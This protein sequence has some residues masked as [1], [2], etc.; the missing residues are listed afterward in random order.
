VANPVGRPKGGG[1][2]AW[3]ED[4]LKDLEYCERLRVVIAKRTRLLP[5]G[6]LVW[7][8]GSSGKYGTIHVYG[9]ARNVHVVSYLLEYGEPGRDLEFDHLCRVHMCH[10]PDHLDPTSSRENNLRNPASIIREYATREACSR[11]H[12]YTDE[13]TQIWLNPDGSFRSRRCRTCSRD[14]SRATYARRKARE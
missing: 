2:R 7:L 9:V 13:N 10:N 8:G 1:F 5:T 4:L 6:C 3:G 14:R 11:G 12:E